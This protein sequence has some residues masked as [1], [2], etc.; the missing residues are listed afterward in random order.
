MLTKADFVFLLNALD[1]ADVLGTP[2]RLPFLLVPLMLEWF[3]DDPLEAIARLAESGCARMVSTEVVVI[4]PDQILKNSK[5]LLSASAGQVSGNIVELAYLRWSLRSHEGVTKLAQE[6][7]IRAWYVGRSPRAP[8]TPETVQ[9]RSR[10]ELQ[11]QFQERQNQDSLGHLMDQDE[12]LPACTPMRGAC[13]LIEFPGSVSG[14]P[15][16]SSR[17]VYRTP[18]WLHYQILRDHRYV[19]E[20]NIELY[21]ECPLYEGTSYATFNHHHDH[22][23]NERAQRQAWKERGE[24]VSSDEGRYGPGCRWRVADRMLGI[25][26]NIAPSITRAQ[27]EDFIA[28]GRGSATRVRRRAHSFMR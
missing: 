4:Y 13:E 3:V 21:G 22:K 28:T 8:S 17:Y 18:Q 27:A 25:I 6:E 10:V 24:F 5:D 12:Y 20:V 7:L 23:I 26:E 9:N 1:V 16:Q 19:E 15:A 11:R 14:E 2:R